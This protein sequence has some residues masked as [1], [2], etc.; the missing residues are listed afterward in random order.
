MDNLYLI[1]LP[2]FRW[3]TALLS[4][5]LIIMWIYY[6][7][8]SN[9]KPPVY[10]VL[11]SAY[12]EVYPIHLRE[13]IIGRTKSSDIFF[14][15]RG[16]HKKQALL[17]TQGDDWFIAP[18]EG[19]FAI[20]MQNITRPAPLNFGDKLEFSG[21][22]FVFQQY[23]PATPYGEKSPG[24]ALTLLILTL[25]QL[26]VFAELLLK[27]GTVNPL[28]V[29][30]FMGL[31][32]GQWLYFAIG[33]F[34]KSF[35]FILE[36]PVL[37][38]STLGLSLCSFAGDSVILKHIVCYTVGFVAYLVLAKLL[39]YPGALLKL[40]RVVMVL[41]LVLLYYTAFFG[42][43]INSS[44][45]WLS[46]GDN[47][48]FQPSE[49]MKAAFVFAGGT[50]LYNVIK[51]PARMW[52]FIIY[53]LLCMGALAIMLDFGAVA[54]FFMG[55]LMILAMR[56]ASPLIIGGITGCAILGAAG[57]I[58][59]YPY[60]ARRFSVWLHAWENAGTTGYQQTRTMMFSASGGLLGVGGGNGYLRDV[61]AAE[62]DLVF[63]II[64]EEWGGI[65]ALAAA[66]CFV[67]F[68][69]Y[70]Y[71]LIR[72]TDSLFYAITLGGGAVMV[73]FQAA[74]NIFGSLDLLPLTGVTMIFVSRG[75]TSLIAAWLMMAFFKGAE[76]SPRIEVSNEY[77]E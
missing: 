37:Y 50:T 76:I 69:V 67:A 73:I 21:Q 25:F 41:S 44:R 62:T 57:V 29:L 5:T 48:S 64:S 53:A 34:A 61:S 14:N 30:G 31:V 10:A 38:L 71:R 60:V 36:I 49:L 47:F 54:I 4:V 58:M 26:T 3:L 27:S 66:L 17:Y 15:F 32:V 72:K 13:N 65:V 75:G 55:L 9:K 16:I 20:N 23:V 19:N 12:G 70:A 8:K 52:E 28:L 22:T 40:Q 33:S 63:G 45:N 11:R 46:I 18:L 59:I 1:L 74:L 51:K 24:G 2:I 39:N 35:K 6:F 68:G 56:Q 42:D 43:V 77:L 7:L